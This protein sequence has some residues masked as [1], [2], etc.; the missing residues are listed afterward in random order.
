MEK[1]GGSG[2]GKE[3][4]WDGISTC[5][6]SSFLPIHCLSRNLKRTNFR[7]LTMHLREIIG[8]ENAMAHSNLQNLLAPWLSIQWALPCCSLASFKVPPAVFLPLFCKLQWFC[9]NLK[10]KRVLSSSCCI[11]PLCQQLFSPAR[12]AQNKRLRF[13]PGC[14]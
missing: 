13:E 7:Q 14:Y 1:M 11:E 6:F 8:M 10:Y 4:H 9:T 2:M 3:G 5:W 12:N